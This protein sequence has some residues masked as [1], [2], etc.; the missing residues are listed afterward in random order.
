[1]G[2]TV[3][4]APLLAELGAAIPGRGFYFVASQM[5]QVEEIATEAAAQYAAKL[6]QLARVAQN[7]ISPSPAEP[8][9]STR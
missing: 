4:L 7:V 5:D 9:A 8:V 1:M 3:N 2:P 6:A